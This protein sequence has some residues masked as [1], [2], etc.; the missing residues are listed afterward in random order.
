MIPGHVPTPSLASGCDNPT[1]KHGKL[2]VLADAPYPTKCQKLGAPLD[3][4]AGTP[5][6]SASPG[7]SGS[8]GSGS[9][10]GTGT[11]SGTGAVTTTGH[12]GPVTGTVVNLAAS[13]NN[14]TALGLLTGGLILIAIA[15]PP[16]VYAVV[17][18]RRQVGR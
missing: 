2:V 8:A 1:L 5:A 11:G 6:T 17:R 12:A 18:R 4:S 15:V 14:P 7:A 9:G 16:A 13:D 10:S 3:C